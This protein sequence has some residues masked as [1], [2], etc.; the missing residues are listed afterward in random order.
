MKKLLYLF[1]LLLLT[2]FLAG[3]GSVISK[4]ALYSV[5]YETD[6]AQVKANPERNLGKTLILGGLILENEVSDAGSTLEILKY[7]LDGRDEPQEPDEESGRFLVKTNRLLDPSIYE[8]GR[9]VTLVGT[10]VGMETRPLQKANYEYPVFSLVELH[11]WPEKT[12]YQ[13]QYY[14]PYYYDPF[15]Y[16]YHS[17]YWRGY[18]YW[19]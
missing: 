14:Y 19:W 8:A 9:L 1:G 18:P 16:R 5:N 13:N 7:T 4:D 6:Y 15:P 11:L 2:G 3:C 10:L 17:P 12:Y